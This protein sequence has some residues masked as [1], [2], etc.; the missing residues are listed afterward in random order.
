MSEI[1]V[2]L[3]EAAGLEGVA[4]TAMLNRIDRSFGSIRVK[5]VNQAKG[6]R[7]FTLVCLDSL[8]SKAQ[9]AY[10]KA[11]ETCTETRPNMPKSW[12]RSWA[13]VSGRCTA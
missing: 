6:G 8:S 1:Y 3:E 7:P 4:Y 13:S 2:S 10:R 11:H 12:R 5:R 9:R